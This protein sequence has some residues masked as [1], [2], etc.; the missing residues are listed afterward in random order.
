MKFRS[1]DQDPTTSDL[2]GHKGWSGSDGT[3]QGA[4]NQV[5]SSQRPEDCHV[6]DHHDGAISTG[7]S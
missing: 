1:G 7:L 5:S 2:A 3:R 6:F 4:T